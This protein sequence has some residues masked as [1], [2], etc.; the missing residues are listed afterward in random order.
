MGPD[1]VV[2]L[3]PDRDG[4]P[5]LWQRLKPMLVQAFVPELAVEA[6]DVAVLHRPAR[7]YQDV[8]NPMGLCPCHEG[9]AGEFRPIVSTHRIRIAAKQGRPIQQP[10]HI[11]A[12]NAV[13]GNDVHTL[14]AEIVRHGQALDAPA[15]GQAVA[16]EIHAPHL[17][18]A[19]RDLQRHALAYRPFGLLAFPHGQVS[20]AVQPIHALVIHPGK[21]RTQQ[22]MDTPV[23]KASPGLGNI[24][25]RGAQHLGPLVRHRRVTE[26]IPG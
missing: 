5:G 13:V 14:V 1:L 23:A 16:H 19:L 18:D 12:A 24:D 11:L 7:L 9:T 10:G 3:P 15:V 21:F 4:M 8:A 22:V 25:D 20:G 17:I 6:L 26:T 2:V